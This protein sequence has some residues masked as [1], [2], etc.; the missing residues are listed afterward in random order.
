MYT[1]RINARATPFNDNDCCCHMAAMEL[2]WPIVR[3]PCFAALRR[4]LLV[5]SGAHART[6]LRWLGNVNE[7]YA[8]I[9]KH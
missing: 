4:W 6:I 9:F 3:G 1:A 7:I 5:A 8:P 2:V